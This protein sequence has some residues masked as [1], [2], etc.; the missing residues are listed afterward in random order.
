MILLQTRGEFYAGMEEFGQID[1][2]AIFTLASR[3]SPSLLLPAQGDTVSA[4]HALSPQG[5]LSP[6]TDEFLTC[7]TIC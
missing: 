7:W 6:W 2:F 1:Y 3:Y 5:E 4:S